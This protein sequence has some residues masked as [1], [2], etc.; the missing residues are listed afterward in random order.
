M[1]IIKHSTLVD[2]WRR[3]PVTEQPLK[4]WYQIAKGASW[5]SMNA[6]QADFPKAKV[7]NGERA[8]FGICGGN[9]RLVTAFFFPAG[10]VWIKFIGTHAV[11]DKID[12]LTVDLY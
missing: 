2:F 4:S 3:H 5:R 11:Y 8:R 9:Y 10:Q 1:R 12:A 7:L 6:V